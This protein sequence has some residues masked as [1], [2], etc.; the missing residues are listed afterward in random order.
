MTH[1]FHRTFPTSYPDRSSKVQNLKVSDGN[2]LDDS[3]VDDGTLK[4]GLGLSTLVEVV[5][6]VV[7]LYLS[8]LVLNEVDLCQYTLVLGVVGLGL[9]TQVLVGVIEVGHGHHDCHHYRNHW[10][11]VDLV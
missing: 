9:C 10:M 3:R 6:A 2:L 7:G 5:L 8:T 1:K 11:K 4:E